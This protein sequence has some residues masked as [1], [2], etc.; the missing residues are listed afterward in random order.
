MIRSIRAHQRGLTL[1]ELLVGLVLGLFIA[2]AAATLLAAQLREQRSLAVENRLMQDL[3]TASDVVVRDLRRA[4]YWGAAASGIWMAGASGVAP[5]PYAALSP[6][7]AASDAARFR[8]S[9]DA[10]ENHVVDSNEEFGLRLRNG[11]IE[12]LLGAGN[13]QSLTD[14]ATL[15]V[16]GFS[17]TP[18]TQEVSLEAHCTAACAA[19]STTC[20]P[21]QQLRSLAIVVSA[22]SAVDP[23]VVRSLRSEVRVRNDAVIGACPA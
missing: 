5:N 21:R 8:Y 12:L 14:A 10:V 13:W 2:A 22:R 23:S 17:I 3:R 4:G 6:D 20:P 18:T 9:R 7:A 1:V 19:G 16:T 11:A 15:S